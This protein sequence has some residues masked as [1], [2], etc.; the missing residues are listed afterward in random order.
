MP[1]FLFP[2]LLGRG[3]GVF[4]ILTGSEQAQSIA[5]SLDTQGFLCRGKAHATRD[6]V[7]HNIKVGIFKFH[8]LAAI[9][10]NEVIVMRALEEVRIVEAFSAAE[11]N[12]AQHAT[13]YEMQDGTID[14]GS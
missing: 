7:L 10:A 11:R 13:L 8:D 14:R 12:L 6:T 4:E 1:R 9:H 5:V 2:S 3:R